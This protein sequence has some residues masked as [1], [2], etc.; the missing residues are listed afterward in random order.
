MVEVLEYIDAYATFT[1]IVI[2]AAA[3]VLCCGS[4]VVC[5]RRRVSHDENMRRDLGFP[6]ES[7]SDNIIT[8]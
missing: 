1:N 3:A 8:L 6:R 5:M 4:G 7:P 2:G